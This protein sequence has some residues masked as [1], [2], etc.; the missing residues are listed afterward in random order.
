MNYEILA[1]GSKGNCLVLDGKIMIDCGIPY[2]KIKDKTKDLK[3]VC[4]THQHSDH[5]NKAT[6][7][8]LKREKPNLKFVCGYYL[9]P[10][11]VADCHVDKKNIF[12]LELDK[13]YDLG[14]CK[15]KI[16]GLYHDVPN[17]CY[18]IFY[19]QDKIFYATDTSKIDHITAKNYSWYFIEGNYETDDNLYEDIKKAH[20]EGKYTYLERVLKTHLSQAQAYEWLNK[21]KNEM[22]KYIFM[23]KHEDK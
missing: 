11:L 13:W 14:L 17:V 1:S 4:L 3:V 21:N 9:V 18:H 20:E 8:K 7:R 2:A 22:S 12:V 10:K 16:Q 19:N 15:I 23:H 6:I 5:F